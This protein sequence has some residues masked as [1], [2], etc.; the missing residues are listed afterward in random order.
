MLMI[1][2]TRSAV[3]ANRE[4]P[5][6]ARVHVAVVWDSPADRGSTTA[7]VVGNVSSLGVTAGS[8]LALGAVGHAIVELHVGLLVGIDAE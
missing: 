8:V 3:E 6:S 2:S 7:L 1:S 4:D 5:E